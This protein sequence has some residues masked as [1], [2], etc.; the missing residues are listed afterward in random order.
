MAGT[1]EQEQKHTEEYFN[2][3]GIDVK[4][5]LKKKLASMN[6]KA[7]P[8]IDIPDVEEKKEETPTITPPPIKEESD[9]IGD[10][11]VIES[12][13]KQIQQS[14]TDIELE[15]KIKNL[16]DELVDELNYTIREL[17][18]ELDNFKDRKVPEIGS[19]D[20]GGL[21]K[22][23]LFEVVTRV[24]DELLINI[25]YDIP[26][27]SLIATQVSRTFDDGTV[28][29]AI[30]SVNITV[31]NDGYRYDFKVDV[32]ILN[33]IIHYPQYIQRGIKIIPITREKILEEL[34][35][36]SFRKMNIDKPYEG[37]MN[38]YNNIGD[39]I[40]R[41]PDDQKWYEISNIEPPPVGLP[42]DHIYYP[43][44]DFK[45]KNTEEM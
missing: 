30:V 28:S 6:K 45:R 24:L 11:E 34:E 21:Y 5:L 38:L 31:P 10:E 39:N 37:R 16:R 26:D 29:D 40:H 25:F 41:R 14:L 4:K 35:S 9:K 3:L 12:D 42:R 22:E 32:P 1:T 36:V 19:F 2:Q 23:R 44:K 17:K 43:K 8:P 15:Q 13:L 27:Y 33:G 20:S 7:A 18:T